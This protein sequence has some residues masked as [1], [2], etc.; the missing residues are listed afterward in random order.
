MSGLG[1][2]AESAVDRFA[3]GKQVGEV[4]LNQR[5]V[6]P[7][8]RAGIVF[9][10]NAALQFRKVIFL[11][12]VITAFSRRFLVHAVFARPVLPGAH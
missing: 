7:S 11:S 3:V 4:R 10:S 6:R 12:H 1:Q 9:A 8:R 2:H 5:Q